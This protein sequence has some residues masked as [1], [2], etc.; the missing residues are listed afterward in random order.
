MMKIAVCT[1]PIRP[2]PTRYP[3]FGSMAI[4]DA[5]RRIGENVEFYNI[6]YFRF[7]DTEIETFFKDNQFD[8][9]GISAVVSTA[10]SYTKWL[11]QLI[12]RVA[13]DT[14]IV[15]GGNLAAS[16]EILLRKCNVDF[17]V[18]GDGEYVMQDLVRCL[19]KY[20]EE[21]DRDALKSVRGIC[22]LDND[23]FRFTGYG[24][25]PDAASIGYP[26]FSILDRDHSLEYFI[27]DNE[28]INGRTWR[29]SSD[30]PQLQLGKT[31]TVIMAKGCVAR[32]TFCH[33]W[34]KGY[35]PQPVETAL[36][37][38]QQL[39]SAHGVTHL[40]IG[41]ENFGADRKLTNELV[42]GL[43]KLGVTWTVAGVRARTVRPED[44]MHWRKNGCLA[45][46]FGIESG[47]QKILEIMEKHATVDENLNALRWVSDAGISTIVQLVIGMP[48]ETDETIEETI[49]FLRNVSEFSLDWS[50][51]YPSE[52]ISINYAQALPGTPLYE[53][54]RENGYLGATLD[55]EEQ[56]LI[57]ISDTDA[58]KEDHF[59]N[60]TGLPLLKVLMWRPIILAKIDAH[61]AEKKGWC[62]RL[63][64]L[65][66]FLYYLGLLRVR[67][68][69]RLKHSKVFSM[70]LAAVDKKL[71]GS[72]K[73]DK[74]DDA[75]KSGYFNIHSNLKLAPLLMNPVTKRLFL[76][77]VSILVAFYRGKSL[78]HSVSLLKD[79][80]KWYLAGSRIGEGSHIPSRSLRKVIK[81]QKPRPSAKDVND[82]MTPLRLGR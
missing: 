48:G 64:L 62:E 37:H 76:P 66:V 29:D 63:S 8:V 75:G 18:V 42:A 69:G 54:A 10:Y 43:G 17:C 22:F 46:Y 73:K 65:A 14:R 47:S 59:I 74:V 24:D 55:D 5:L 6:D 77:I 9:V 25:K 15:V 7:S 13:P 16:A 12:K 61:H 58:Y 41:D 60:Y 72:F 11:S 79:Y 20:G 45:A 40:N 81:L 30:L 34:E 80:F 23:N 2:I 32:C 44:L 28:A 4:I 21:I 78:A 51:K 3:P 36:A 1:T 52:L 31:T 38:V 68:T 39:K 70:L 82:E 26:D 56:Y 67:V 35:R 49:D 71:G 33:R 50:D 27:H 53:W 57:Q 19:K